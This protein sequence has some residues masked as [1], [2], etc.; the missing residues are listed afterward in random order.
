MWVNEPTTLTS[1][2]TSAGQTYY[3]SGKIFDG[4]VE[5]D[6]DM[7]PKPKLAT[8]WDLS[9]DGLTSALHPSERR[10]MARWQ[11]LHVE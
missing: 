11:T 8:S 6:F 9:A 10:E 2:Y 4:L 7:K 5:Y 1:A 3:T